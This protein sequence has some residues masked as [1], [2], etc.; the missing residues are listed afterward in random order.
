M[1][2]ETHK[3]KEKM[4]GDVMFTTVGGDEHEHNKSQGQYDSIYYH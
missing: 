1:L 3:Y 4:W 2:F